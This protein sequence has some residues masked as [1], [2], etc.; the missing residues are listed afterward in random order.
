M[1]N[2][3]KEIVKKQLEE[4]T[5][6]WAGKP[7]MTQEEINAVLEFAERKAKPVKEFFSNPKNVKDFEEKMAALED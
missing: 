3:Y 5:R 7:R 6:H 2:L 1:S 4:S